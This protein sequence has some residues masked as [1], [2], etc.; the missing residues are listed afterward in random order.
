MEQQMNW[1]F[2]GSYFLKCSS[3]KASESFSS[4]EFVHRIKNGTYK[5]QVDHFRQRMME[6]DKA[7]L[8]NIKRSL[9]AFIFS[10]VCPN[11]R[12]K[13]S[14]IEM[15]NLLGVDYDRHE[16]AWSYELIER[17]KEVGWIAGG[18][19]TLSYGARILVVIPSIPRKYR[20][21]VVSIILEKVD[22]L[23]G[24]KHD[25][26]AVNLFRMNTVS[27]DPHAWVREP[28][29]CTM[30]IPFDDEM[31]RRAR[32]GAERID[33]LERKKEAAKAAAVAK[34][35]QVRAAA[36]AEGS[37]VAGV[38]TDIPEANGPRMFTNEQISD[39]VDKFVRRY[40]YVNN[41]HNRALLIYGT[42]AHHEG[43]ASA[44]VVALAHIFNKLYG[45]AAYGY[46]DIFSRF[47][48]GF[49]HPKAY[50]KEANADQFE[51]KSNLSNLSTAHGSEEDTTETEE[52][53]QGNR[54]YFGDKV[55]DN[56]PAFI[57]V[58]LV[59]AR[60]K[61]Q[62]D[63][64]LSAILA[65]IS[66]TMA[67]MIVHYHGQKYSANVSFCGI[68][69]AGS[70]KGKVMEA[71]RLLRYIQKE[72][73]EQH[74]KDLK[75]YCAK[76]IRWDIEQKKAER[77]NRE[78]DHK[79][80][81]GEP[82]YHI[83]FL[84]NACTSRSK[85]ISDLAHSTYGMAIFDGEI[86]GMNEARSSEIGKADSVYRKAIMNEPIGKNY[87]SDDSDVE[88]EHPKLSVI[89]TGTMGQ[90]IQFIR[91][92][93]NGNLSRFAV[94]LGDEEIKWDKLL[95]SEDQEAME[96]ELDR[97][98]EAAAQ[99]TLEMFRFLEQNPTDVRL[100]ND[101]MQ[102]MDLFFDYAIECL[103]EED[104]TELVSMV[105][106]GGLTCARLCATLTGIRKFLNK[107]TTQRQFV[108]DTDFEVAL[109]MVKVFMRHTGEASLY[110]PQRDIELRTPERGR[111]LETQRIASEVFASLPDEFSSQ[112]VHE[113]FRAHSHLRRS[114]IYNVIQAWKIGGQIIS[115]GSGYYAKVKK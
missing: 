77:E 51:E 61:R 28:E 30:S 15:S 23:V 70:G 89:M 90:L 44:D 74:K 32:E 80:D 105:T 52:K 21:M 12:K 49:Q 22:E 71:I 62:R 106:R 58:L 110:F 34:V 35:A 2:Q 108:D 78:A 7:E 3:E 101:Q 36:I 84:G 18:Y 103:K 75:N 96:E 97:N 115:K 64:L 37:A 69:A 98:Y 27:Y 11:G 16:Q 95:T 4:Q 109:Q 41:R 65:G 111:S 46:A 33:E 53:P 87:L 81:P 76:K 45:S 39:F 86:D 100:T 99:F 92:I 38:L 66:A 5:N 112:K 73:D 29:E 56:L 93:T 68:A 13:D 50:H 59:S 91:S 85:L 113:I 9:P 102:R 48:W 88:V 55:Y 43:F 6:G 31:K 94:L 1:N 60:N 10:G 25:E 47:N 14:P 83:H 54:P 40:P 107:D 63:M 114:T 24:E 79:L 17:L 82:P 19:S 26:Q 72:Y 67:N 8:H 57:T 20:D 104:H 42:Y